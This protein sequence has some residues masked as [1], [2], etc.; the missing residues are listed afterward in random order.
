MDAGRERW[1]EKSVELKNKLLHLMIE[2]AEGLHTKDP[3]VVFSDKSFNL[4]MGVLIREDIEA[5][6]RARPA[7]PP[8]PQPAVSQAMTSSAAGGDVDMKKRIYVANKA[9][10]D[11]TVTTKVAVE[12]LSEILPSVKLRDLVLKLAGTISTKRWPNYTVVWLIWEKD[13]KKFPGLVRMLPG[14][15]VD[16]N[17]LLNTPIIVWCKKVKDGP[18]DWWEAF[19]PQ[20]KALR[21]WSKGLEEGKREGK[22]GSGVLNLGAF[23]GEAV[24]PEGRRL[25]MGLESHPGSDDFVKGKFLEAIASLEDNTLL[26]LLTCCSVKDFVV[27]ILKPI[28][29]NFDEMPKEAASGLVLCDTPELCDVKAEVWDAANAY[30]RK[31]TGGEAV[32]RGVYDL[33]SSGLVGLGIGARYTTRTG[34]LEDEIHPSG[35]FERADYDPK[36]QEPKGIKKAVEMEKRYGGYEDRRTVGFRDRSP[37]F[38]ADY[39][40]WQGGRDREDEWDDYAEAGV[41]GV[42]DDKYDSWRHSYGGS[43][44]RFDRR[45]GGYGEDRHDRPRTFREPGTRGSKDYSPGRLWGGEEYRSVPETSD[46]GRFVTPDRQHQDSR[47]PNPFAR[48]EHRSGLPDQGRSQPRIG[49][50]SQPSQSQVPPQYPGPPGLSNAVTPARG[51]LSTPIGLGTGHRGSQSTGGRQD[52]RSRGQGS[53]ER[54]GSESDRRRLEGSSRQEEGHR[55]RHHVDRP[56]RHDR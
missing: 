49:L 20:A 28:S 18:G 43:P 25:L 3:D 37:G 6:F 54:G 47:P 40:Q 16:G 1:R 12:L 27:Q 48:F 35:S 22:K 39:D 36:Q 4:R 24:K 29:K 23:W 7:R 11:G 41:Y 17:G 32:G 19:M 2:I 10:F 34:Y 30:R 26:A 13:F 21:V 51:S 55:K 53:Q 9:A 45:G 31:L 14:N 52:D 8:E 50:G 33:M 46:Y 15:C 5:A 56:S 44:D 38:T 42:C